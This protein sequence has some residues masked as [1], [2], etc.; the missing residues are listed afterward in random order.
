MITTQL[1]LTD[2][3]YS[4]VQATAGLLGKS[5]AEVLHDAV[6]AFASHARIERQRR[7]IDE[8]FGMWKDRTDIPDYRAD[9]DAGGRY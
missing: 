8:A 7:R 1:Q 2:A 9:R 5:I 6:T 3:E 4:E